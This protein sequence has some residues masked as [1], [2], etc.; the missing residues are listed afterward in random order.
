MNILELDKEGIL[1]LNPSDI[2]NFLMP[3]ELLHIAKLLEAYWAY[4]YAAADEGRLGLH[5]ELKSGLHSDAF[6]VSRILL[7]PENIREII[8]MQMVQRLKQAGIVLHPSC[9]V[10]VPDGATDLAKAI[11]YIL[12]VPVA[13]MKKENGIILLDEPIANREAILLVEDI[14]TRGTGFKEGAV[15]VMR[16]YPDA[17]FIGVDPVIVNRGGLTEIPIPERGNFLIVPAVNLQVN[18]WMPEDCPLCKM[19]SKAI[20][21]KATDENWRLITTSQLKAA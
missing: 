20:K 4:D 13:K 7:K 11:G 6:F 15:A 9:I 14:C 21:P 3:A 1:N 18:D 17:T 8:A 5:A 2:T 10:G 12:G 16:R 19:G